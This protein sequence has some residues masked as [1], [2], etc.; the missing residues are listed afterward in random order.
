MSTKLDS[1]ALPEVGV[2]RKGDAK[3]KTVKNGREVETVGPDLKDRFR[4]SFPP[5]ADEYRK[6]FEARYHT[7]KPESIRAMVL[8][9]SVWQSWSWA[10]EAYNAGRMIAKADD[11]HYLVLRDP[12]TGAYKVR[13]GEP[14]T[15]YSPGGC[16]SYERDGKHFDL[17]LRTVGRLRLFVPEMERLCQFQLKTTSYYDR[18]NIERQLS[19]IQMLADTLNGGNAAGIPLRIFRMEQ[20]V[21]WNK[22]DGGASRVKK[23]LVNIEADSEWVRAATRRLHDFALT[24]EMAVGLLTPP[25]EM[26]VG[27]LTPPAEISGAVEP[28]HEEI[29]DNPADSEIIDAESVAIPDS[30]YSLDL[31]NH[32]VKSKYAPDLDY[33]ALALGM[34]SLPV[35]IT[36]DIATAWLKHYN[37]AIDVGQ[38]PEQAAQIADAHYVEWAKK[39]Q[40]AA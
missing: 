4:V 9:R 35:D 32:L 10:N 34:S 23:W 24:G 1:L 17:K 15:E 28:E 40:D 11:T 19:T 36:V 29:D 8:S 25:G 39:Q 7:L 26:A 31:L 6:I 22:P 20:E 16:V 14:F 18:L 13:D 12:L 2:I 21:T 33:A 3:V 27:L 30:E 37:G 5:G 38:Q